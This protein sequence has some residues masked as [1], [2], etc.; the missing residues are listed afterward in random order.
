MAS[1]R[2]NAWVA[3]VLGFSITGRIAPVDDDVM[4]RL[5]SA[6]DKL[7]PAL[8]QAARATPAIAEGISIHQVAFQAALAAGDLVT[9]RE[10]VFELASLAKPRGAAEAA[11]IIP[12]GTVAAGI[13]SLNEARERWDGAL[14]AAQSGSRSLQSEL[15]AVFP[16]EAE[17]FERILD[18]YWRDLADVINAA[19]GQDAAGFD[20]ILQMAESL[21]TEM[22]ADELFSYL[23]SN[24]IPVRPAFITALDD[25]NSMLRR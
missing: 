20:G 3:R 4:A 15:E 7:A 24:G 18:S 11:A 22:M 23:E 5:R 1:D 10:H 6:Y 8:I 13:K 12:E 9:A 14:A 2:Q 21:R 17:G 16:P 19:K 25:V